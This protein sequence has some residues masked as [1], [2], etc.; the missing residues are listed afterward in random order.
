MTTRIFERQHKKGA[1]MP[2][3]MLAP[4]VIILVTVT[5][6]LTIGSEINQQIVAD[7]C[8]SNCT[9]IEEWQD[10]ATNVTY[11]FNDC[12]NWNGTVYLACPTGD[13]IVYN[14]SEMGMHSSLAVAQWMDVLGL[15]IGA[16]VILGVMYLLMKN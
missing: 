5:I 9:Y 6:I 2:L 14:I 8:P 3:Q 15:V 1:G 13:T 16:G 11:Y 4:A 7:N 10:P 12:K